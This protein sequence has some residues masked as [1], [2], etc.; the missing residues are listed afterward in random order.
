MSER[1]RLL[2]LEDDPS[3]QQLVSLALEELDLELLVC[4]TLAKARSTLA[5]A[6]VQM[7]ITDLMLP[8]GSGLDLIHD[9][10]AQ[11]GLHGEPPVLV[12]SAGLVDGLRAQLVELGVWR[13]LGKPCSVLDLEAS[14]TEGLALRASTS[15]P[16]AA[17]TDAGHSELALPPEQATA[18]ALH[19]GGDEP[20]YRAFRQACLPQFD[21]DRQQ[22]DAACERRDAPAL[23]RLAHSLKS[24][25]LTL[26]HPAESRL[27]RELEDRAEQSDWAASLRLWQDLRCRL[28]DGP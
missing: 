4:G 5:T 3:I 18:V 7:I 2:L 15:A 19:F 10:R 14:V 8:D 13:M 25:L 22:G 26:G 17:A 20:L 16:T 24:V 12:F 11:P 1:P 28:P 21:L 6:P 9:L 23:R 27:A